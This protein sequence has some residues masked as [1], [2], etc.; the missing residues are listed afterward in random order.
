MKYNIIGS[1]SKG[2]CIIVEDFLMLDCGLSYSKI[3]E[4]L[5]NIKLIF[6]SHK[7]HDH[8]NMAC[9]KQLTY[10]YP[11]IK[12]VTG[13]KDVV[14]K[15]VKCGARKKNIYFLKEGIR[16]DLGML[17]VRLVY[18]YHDVDNY[19]IKWE[20]K[21]KK[22]IYCVDTSRLDH[23]VAEDYDLYLIEANYKEEILQQHIDQCE[24]DDDRL[25]YLHRVENTHLSQDQANKFLLDNMGDNSV[26]EYI[27]QSKFNFEYEEEK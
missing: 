17:K 7:H 14:E 5:K 19:G 25:I 3:R 9:I 6:I 26:Y 20:Y 24:P 11:T 22:G 2:N 21:G 18:L 1:S 13:S 16:Y 23:I 27:H 12:F 4:Y 15:L 10:S 8:L